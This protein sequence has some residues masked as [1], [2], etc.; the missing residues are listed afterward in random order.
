MSCHVVSYQPRGTSPQTLGPKHRRTCLTYLKHAVCFGVSSSISR[1]NLTRQNIQHFHYMP[2]TFLMFGV[3][4]CVVRSLNHI[5]VRHIKLCCILTCCIV[6]HIILYHII[7]Y[8][9]CYTECITLYTVD[10]STALLVDVEPPSP[11]AG[12][13][14]RCGGLPTNR[15]HV[16]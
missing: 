2:S 8:S 7:T 4:N 15:S 9:V 6:W 1:I 10:M 16:W 14:W 13:W 11:P 3:L 5:I 12:V